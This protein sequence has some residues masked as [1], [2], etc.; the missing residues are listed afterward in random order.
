MFGFDARPAFLGLAKCEPAEFR[1]T[2]ADDPAL[3]RSSVAVQQG[4]DA[5]KVQTG[6][7]ANFSQPSAAPTRA[8]DVDRDGAKLLFVQ[9]FRNL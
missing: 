2:F 1:P 8:A 9:V 7:L 4:F 6:A 3:L 5:V